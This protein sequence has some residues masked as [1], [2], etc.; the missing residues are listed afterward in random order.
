M[1]FDLLR[2]PSIMILIIAAVRVTVNN[3]V[4]AANAIDILLVGPLL[5]IEGL[6]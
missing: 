4:M 3:I 1:Y 6:I 5:I 2:L